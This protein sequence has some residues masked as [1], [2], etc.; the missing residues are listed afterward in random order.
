MKEAI[1]LLWSG[2]KDSMLALHS[3]RESG[4]Y[5]VRVLLTTMTLGYD[6]ISMHGVRRSLLEAQAASLDL[7][8]KTVDI[9]RACSH[10]DYQAAM[11]AALRDLHQCGIGTVAAGDIFLDDVRRY[12][13]SLA[14]SAGMAS[15]FPL[16]KQD[17]HALALGF[18]DLGFQA[19][20]TCIDTEAL[21][22]SFAGRAF[23]RQF[24]HDLPPTVDRCGENGE[25][26]T[27]VHAG[28]LFEHPVPNTAGE[29]IVRDGRFCFCDL[30]EGSSS[31][32]SRS[33]RGTSM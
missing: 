1:A 5:E 15:L 24:L 29:T 8:S 33:G 19:T 20:T 2:G 4:R 9:P 27:F 10:Q 22:A 18:I 23:D 7:T 32:Y 25:F 12:R 26:H 11:V 3:L 28:P 6:R 16:W 14:T 31:E 21:E 17:T 13:E 30:L